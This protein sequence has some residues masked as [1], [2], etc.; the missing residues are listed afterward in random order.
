VEGNSFK[1][2][3]HEPPASGKH[4]EK[5]FK[6]PYFISKELA[7]KSDDVLDELVNGRQH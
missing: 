2:L 3:L 5:G 4:M 1:F 7:E 6:N